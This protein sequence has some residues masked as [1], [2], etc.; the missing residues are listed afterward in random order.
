[1]TKNIKEWAAEIA[2]SL[3][4]RKSV[5][6]NEAINTFENEYG[7]YPFTSKEEIA[8]QVETQLTLLQEF[9]SNGYISD[10]QYFEMLKGITGEE[11]SDSETYDYR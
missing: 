8:V 5:K 9:R 7:D 4:S 2:E 6:T 11:S 10:D 3:W 1:M